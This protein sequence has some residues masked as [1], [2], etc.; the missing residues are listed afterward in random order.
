LPLGYDT[1][2]TRKFEG[3]SQLSGGQWQRI[4]L[5]RAL[6]AEPDLL[7]LDEP[8]AALDPR[9]EFELYESV[10]SLAEDRA[11]LLISHRLASCRSADRIYVLEEG[12][13][14]EQGTHPELI[15][16][17]GLYEELYRMQVSSLTAEAG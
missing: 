11:I 14:T 12:L 1:L 2:L 16:A 4:A 9:A 15:A 3:G 7:I 8:S 13:I 10:R 5:A 17:G 6:F